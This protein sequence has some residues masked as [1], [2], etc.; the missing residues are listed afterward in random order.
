MV[1]SPP[2]EQRMLPFLHLEVYHMV[3]DYAPG[4]SNSELSTHD[5]HCQGFK[6]A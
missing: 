5:S 3:C 1:T 6:W 4:S 2:L